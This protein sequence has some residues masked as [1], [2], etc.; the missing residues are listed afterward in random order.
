M[1]YQ[2]SCHCGRLAYEVEG[3][4]EQAMDCNCS[5]C[6]RRGGLLWFVPR[7]AFTLRTPTADYATYTYNSHKLRHRFCPTCGIAPFSEGSGRDGVAMVAVNIRC[8]E[9]L[10]LAKVTITPYDGASK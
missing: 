10:D 1:T 9:G 7:S 4:I 8:L 6:R 2:G 3:T 5:F